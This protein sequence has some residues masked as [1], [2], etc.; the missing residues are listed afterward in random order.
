MQPSKKL[1]GVSRDLSRTFTYQPWTGDPA[2]IPPRRSKLFA[3]EH[4]EANAYLNPDYLQ[5]YEAF[6]VPVNIGSGDNPRVPEKSY[7]FLGS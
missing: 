7:G 4:V 5:A 3:W 6:G 2:G 1:N